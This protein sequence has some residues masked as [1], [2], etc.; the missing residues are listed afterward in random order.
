[1]C[2][3]SFF[4]IA[5]IILVCLI[6]M[7]ACQSAT[8]ELEEALDLAGQNRQELEEVLTHYQQIDKDTLK[9]KA[10]CFLIK[11]MRWHV[12]DGMVHSENKEFDQ[13]LH[14]ADSIYYRIMTTIK[15][16]KEQERSLKEEEIA[17]RERSGE[18]SEP[19]GAFQKSIVLDINNLN[20]RFLIMHINYMVER[21]K[22]SVFAQN[23][24]FE[25]F[26]EYLLPYRAMPGGDCINSELLSNLMCYQLTQ[27]NTLNIGETVKR[28]NKYMSAIRGLVGLPCREGMLGWRDIFLSYPHDCVS[29]CEFQTQILRTCGIPSAMVFCVANREFVGRHHYCVALDSVGNRIAMNAESNY[30]GKKNWGY[31]LGYR[32]NCFQYM[33]GA[34]KDSPYM[35]RGKGEALPP[36]FRSPA[37][38]EVTPDLRT[39][40]SLSLKVPAKIKNRLAWLYTYSRSKGYI[41]VT[42]GEINPNTQEACFKYVIPGIF[43][44]PA[45]LNADGKPCFWG[46]PLFVERKGNVGEWKSLDKL[47]QHQ[48]D[49]SVVLTRKFPRKPPMKRLAEE[50][51][52]SK[53]YGANRED[54]RDKEELY[55]ISECPGDCLNEYH[56]QNSKAFRYYIYESVNRKSEIAIL[57]YLAD[58]SWHYANTA[59]PLPKEIFSPADTLQPFGQWVKLLPEKPDHSQ[60]FDENIQTTSYR[61]RVVFRLDQP[62]VV[63]CIRVAPLS[64][65]NGIKPD[66][67]YDLFY[68]DKDWQLYA[69]KT[70]RYN[71]LE[72]ENLPAKR[73]YW[74]RNNTRGKEEVPFVIIDGKQEF[75][76]YDVFTSPSDLLD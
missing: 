18:L 30:L 58:T 22:N 1:M 20:A 32:L 5:T 51:V 31:S 41:A 16:P 3:L 46:E 38:K 66:E 52:G 8:D 64:A 25:N 24:S 14:N 70:S 47:L 40:V 63:N 39:T 13:Y 11:N 26:C 4:K 15:D 50:I 75:V 42:W 19:L 54:G 74:L 53:F 57:E 10:A 67:D 12:N 37:I 2:N 71:Y 68:W 43:Y 48:K 35:L 34:Q 21:W 28:Y 27:G 9:Y 59:A 7:E 49:T 72:F 6:G 76:Y 36:D 23:I 62:K 65:D 60:E 45:Y 73:L 55:C 33:F 69:K 17:F 44:F 29:Q 61:E 56:L